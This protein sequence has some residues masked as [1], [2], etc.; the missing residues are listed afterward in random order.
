MIAWLLASGC[1]ILALVTT[2]GW[3]RS[4]RRLQASVSE[5][6]QLRTMVKKR[7]ERPNVFGHEVRTPLTLIRGAAELLAEETP[8]P[9][10]E[11]QHEFVH[12]ISSNAQQVIAL[13]EDLLTE[14]KIESQ[15]FDLHLEHIDLKPLVRQAVR[16]ARRIHFADI[17]FDEQSGSISVMGDSAL[18]M[19]ALRN[20]VANACRHSGDNTLVRVSATTSEGQAIVSV[21]D[22]GG[23]M[24]SSERDTLFD[25]FVVGGSERAGTGLGMMITKRI[26]SQH[27]GHMVVD[28]VAGHGTTILFTIP[29][30]RG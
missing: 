14:A 20:L 21:S 3:V 18:L 13:A 17:R 16:E 1:G 24:S 5:A 19:Q 28:T 6:E 10:T 2:F 23:G 15:L 29:T 25:P 30:N 8:G 26:V 7:V 22:S 27:G 4:H 12:T 11:R 9:L